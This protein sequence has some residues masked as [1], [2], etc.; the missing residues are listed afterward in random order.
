MKQFILCLL[1]FVS[2]QLSFAQ[3][4]GINTTT[5]HNSAALDITATDKGLLVPRLTTTQRTNITSPAKGLLV[6]DTDMNQFHFY[7]GSAWTAIPLSNLTKI[8]DT[9]GNTKIE[10]EQTTNDNLIRFSADGVEYFKMN[11]GTLEVVNTGGSVFIGQQAGLNE[12][13]LGGN[14]NV[15]IGYQALQSTQGS[16]DNVGIGARA[17]WS[18][19]DGNYNVAV[20]T[21]ALRSNNSISNVGIGQKAG[22]NNAT[23]NG[24]VFIGYNA[25]GNE[26][27]S[28]K[29]Y[30]ANSNT[31]TPLLYGDFATKALKINGA[32]N[33]NNAYTLPSVSGT[34]G[35]VLQTDGAGTTTWASLSSI[36]TET[37][38]K[39]GNLSINYLPKWNGSTLTNTQVYDNSLNVGIGTTAPT[40][41]LDINGNLKVNTSIVVDGN[42]ANNGTN[43]NTLLFGTGSG[44]A[45]GS[46]RTIGSQNRYGL[47]FYT[48]HDVQMSITNAGRIG[49]GV[50]NP[51]N[52]LDINGGLAVGSNYAG[53]ETAPDNGA[54]IEG[55]VGIG[56]SAAFFPLTVLGT[57]N[58]MVGVI[59]NSDNGTSVTI[60]NLSSGSSEWSLNVTG[61][62]NEGGSGQLLF[63][64]GTG[65]IP[66][67]ILANNNI[68]IGTTY[69]SSLLTVGA[70]YDCNI[71]PIAQFNTDNHEAVMFA[72]PG[73]TKGLMIGYDGNDIQGRSGIDFETNDNLILNA[74]DGNVGIG[75]NAP[76][77]K[78]DVNGKTKT[79]NLQITAGAADNYVLKSDADGNA[80][81]AALTIFE[82]DPKVGSLTNNYLPKWNGLSLAN[83]Q[84][85][86]NGTNIG[87][88]TSNPTA[89]LDIN[90]SVKATSLQMT[91]GATA[92]Y[93][94]KSD[95]SGNASWASMTTLET[96]PKIGSL[97]SNYLSK[98]NGSTL[99]NTQVFDNGTNIGIGTTTP[100]VKLDV[101]GTVKSTNLQMT[102]GA[103]A[104]YVLK[105][106]VNGNASWVSMTT[107]ETDPKIG[108]LTS[109]Y[110]SK[111]NGSTLSN[112][113]V[114]DDG[115][116]IG[117]GTTTPSVKL[118]VNGT[119]KASQLQMSTDAVYGYVLRSDANGNGYW[120]NPNFLTTTLQDADANTSVQVEKT[121][122]DDKIRFTVGGVERFSMT[123][124]LFGVHNTGGSTF[125]GEKAGENDDLTSNQNTFFG[126]YVG[127]QMATGSNNSA[128]GRSALE[129]NASGN[130]NTA[131]GY[132]TLS[133]N[134]TG[135]GNTAVGT[136]AGQDNTGSNNVFLGY[137]AGA[138]ET[139]S[140]KLYI[141][142]TSTSSPLIYGDFS[143]NTLTV[144]GKM[145]IGTTTPTQA[146][147]V[148][149]GNATNTLSY[150]YLNS[151]NQ[152]GTVS[153]YTANYSIYASDRIAATEFNA[154]SDRRIKK[155]L[156]G[157]NSAEDLST[158]MK[159]K[160]TD[161]K[162]IDSISKGNRAYKKVIAQ[163]VAEVYPNAVSTIKECVP[164]VYKMATIHDGWVK[165]DEQTQ[166]GYIHSEKNTKQNSAGYIHSEKNTKQNSAG[167]IY[168]EKN[169][170]QNLK[171]GDKIK[172]IY[173]QTQAVVDIIEVTIDGFKINT[174]IPNGN[175]FVYGREVDDFHTVDYESLS[176]LNISATQELV[177]QLNDLKAENAGLKKH[178]NTMEADIDMLKTAILKQGDSN[179]HREK[180]DDK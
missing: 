163:E 50:R 137:G 157:S 154:F 179:R 116:N 60:G 53:E 83:T 126:Y 169:T 145:G 103:A 159:I 114:F 61:T 47:D 173:E 118:D 155:I 59:S 62:N 30:I 170:V 160:V 107:L 174:H 113:Q 55:H 4:V 94:L 37:D 82:T 161:Y 176:T 100:S 7:N 38:P 124:A 42:A 95:A 177:K 102:T 32:L 80:S 123:G 122:N 141:D 89:K 119:V 87:I 92:N 106:D 25:G 129:V 66:M 28:N 27:G 84:V 97:T 13:Y 134:L 175:V 131:L 98:W 48:S 68:G 39:V 72:A 3:N 112:T 51:Q 150:A 99:A 74:Y 109:N 151:S 17:L 162:L 127:N 138:S 156:R 75:T 81:W 33:I 49:M 130:S 16:F 78:L 1:A 77:E 10:V 23:G 34:S 158:L 46:A 12:I 167:Y 149:N 35:Q 52:T 132:A 96:D 172:L 71:G 166:A 45:I 110:L 24:N 8:Q 88:G 144:N 142:N 65:D 5:P 133:K 31:A 43:N 120:S 104:N 180:S 20:G 6:F 108:S 178:I 22:E 67:R 41:K 115:T 9:D 70:N 36:L 26:L 93:V 101:N 90:G 21:D 14:Q 11:K 15:G 153:N 54:V 73:I 168:S 29:L 128:F 164:D 140:N 148:V 44:E 135:S 171:V 19:I 86:D 139:G 165:F 64:N 136:F 58:Q 79:T 56:T 105:S 63:Q 69:A 147:L 117:I 85:F 57:E 91:T 40:A 2:I 125:F 143:N 18:N 152:T 76:T 121:V 111:W 146:K